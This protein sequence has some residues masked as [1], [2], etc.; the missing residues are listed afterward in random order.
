MKKRLEK[1]EIRNLPEQF[2]K[3]LYLFR[4]KELYQWKIEGNEIK[5]RFESF[6]L[7]LYGLVEKEVSVEFN[8]IKFIGVVHEYVIS[9]RFEL[10]RDRSSKHVFVGYTESLAENIHDV[11]LWK[12]QDR[13]LVNFMTTQSHNEIVN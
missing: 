1:S 2:C 11:I 6:K 12:S 8:K 9:I 3:K 10:M 5:T 4:P 7:F 13:Q